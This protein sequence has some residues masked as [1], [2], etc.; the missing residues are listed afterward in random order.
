MKHFRAQGRFRR[1][2]VAAATVAVLG[3]TL[4]SDGPAQAVAHKGLNGLIVCG[5][6]LPTTDPP[7]RVVDFEVYVMNP[8]GSGRTNITD[9]NPITDYNPLFTADGKQILYET[10][11]VGQAVDDTYELVLM[12]PDGSNKTPLVLNGRPEDIPKGYHPDGSQIVFSSNRDGNNEIYKMDA[13]GT[14]QVRLTNLPSSESWPRWSPDGTRIVFQ[15]T[16]SGNSEIWTMDPFGNN[17]VKLTNDPVNDSAPDWS[18]DGQITWA[19]NVAGSG[20]EVFKMNG[21]G[22]NQVNLTNRAGYDSIP[23]WSPDGTKIIYSRPIPGDPNFSASGANYEVWSMNA[24][25]GSGVTRLTFNAFDFD[26]RCDWQRLCTIYAAP[27]VATSGTEGDD[28][29]CG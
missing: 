24:A 17:L 21:D 3:S 18:P 14:N 4:I 26:G 2:Q 20:N 11:F 8:D 1:V 15:S 5:G 6:T 9:E 25:D 22:T 12:N 16:M 29:I 23:T 10:E 19:K 7:T 13:D 27:G 28:V